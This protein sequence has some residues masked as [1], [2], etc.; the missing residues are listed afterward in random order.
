MTTAPTHDRGNRGTSSTGSSVAW[1]GLAPEFGIV[2]RMAALKLPDS[3]VGAQL[4]L[5][6]GRDLFRELVAQNLAFLETPPC[7]VH[8][9]RDA[10][11]RRPFYYVGHVEPTP[12]SLALLLGDGLFN[13]R[14][15]LDY[16]AWQLV[17]VGAGG[18]PKVNLKSIAFPIADNPKQVTERFKKDLAE[19]PRDA[20]TA[21]LSMEPYQGGKGHHLWVLHKLNNVD[22]HRLLLPVVVNH[23]NTDLFPGIR[24]NLEKKGCAVAVIGDPRV[25]VR[26][27]KRVVPLKVRTILFV[28][29]PDAE[30]SDSI[31]FGFETVIHEPPVVEEAPIKGTAQDLVDAVVGTVRELS[32]FV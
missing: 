4:K 30:Y 13:L 14:C 27:K 1:G 12:P 20:I 18:A 25:L 2:L 9:D 8:R 26:P 11:S 6:R 16:V 31:M 5:E 28:D 10:K 15:A 3:L 23:L 24:A 32:A 22:K 19:M 7:R 17:H 29:A 21:I